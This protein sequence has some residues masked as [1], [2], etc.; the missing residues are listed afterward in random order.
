MTADLAGTL[1]DGAISQSLKEPSNTIWDQLWC[2][3]GTRESY[4]R[5]IEAG[6]WIGFTCSLSSDDKGSRTRVIEALA[7]SRRAVITAVNSSDDDPA[8]LILD[9]LLHETQHHGQLI[10]Y[11]YGLGLEFPQ[12]WKERW[13]L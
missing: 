6:A 11:V 9:L 4:A 13:N 1:S 2:V 12:S 3:V 7:S 10:R 5:A 8:R